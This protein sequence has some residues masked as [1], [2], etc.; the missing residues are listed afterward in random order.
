MIHGTTL[1][2]N[3]LIERKGVKTALI[4]TRGFRDVLEIGREWR[5]DLFDLHIEMPPP[6]VPRPLRF[7]LNERIDAAGRIL[8]PCDQHEVGRIIATLRQA[9]VRSVA[10]CL[11]HAYLNPEHERA[12][13]GRLR[14]ELPGVSVSL[15]S[16][17]EDDEDNMTG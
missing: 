1:V 11:L 12:L 6:L 7:E 15:S 9:G 5:Y 17:F 14:A 4:T 8:V 10:V 2:A 3:A 16:D 13:G